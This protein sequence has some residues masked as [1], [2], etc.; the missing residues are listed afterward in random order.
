M[1][2]EFVEVK[3]FGEV[4]PKTTPNNRVPYEHQK[5]AMHNMDIINKTDNYSTLIVLPTGGG[6]TYT[7]SGWLLKNAIN[8]KKKIL[9]IAHRQMLLDQAAES[10]QKFAYQETVPN[11]SSFKYRII[12]GSTEHDR[13]INIKATDDIL[14]VSKDSVGRNLAGLDSWLKGENE[15]YFI[16][17]RFLLSSVPD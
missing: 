17:I 5:N 16:V 10:F 11:I 12:S 13:M 14:I 4:F 9:W 1:N 2:K 3:S 6:K 7:A 8:K 15:I